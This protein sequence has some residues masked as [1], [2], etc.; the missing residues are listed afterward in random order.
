MLHPT[1]PGLH[2]IA[3]RLLHNA[4][5]DPQAAVEYGAALHGRLDPRPT[6]REVVAALRDPEHV[7]AAIPPDY[8]NV[9]L[10]VR[11]LRQLERPDLA[12]A[13]LA[14][15]LERRPKDVRVCEYLYS[16]SIDQGDL[17]AAE[18]AGRHCLAV[19][20]SHQRRIALARVLF[21]RGAFQ[22]VV[23]QLGDIPTWRGRIGEIASAWLVLCD[24][25]EALKHW[26]D[27]VHC[28]RQL[29]GRNLVPPNRRD[30]ITRRIERIEKA[31][32]K[33]DLEDAPA[34][35]PDAGVAMPRILK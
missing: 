3:A 27:G 22:E 21:Q 20:P 9:D 18:A 10:V 30:E 17:K 23:Q 29:D 14:R 31:R 33:A 2:T 7:I 5:R 4:G 11:V 34:A 15:V 6:I 19:V 26:T 28:L 25:H 13:W 12:A 24:A 8:P 1:H 35:P 16:I 32:V